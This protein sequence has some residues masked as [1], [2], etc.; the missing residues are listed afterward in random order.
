MTFPYGGYAGKGLYVDLSTG[1]IEP[2][3]V[4]AKTQMF[5]ERYMVD[6]LLQNS[7]G[8]SYHELFAERAASCPGFTRPSNFCPWSYSA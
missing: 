4:G 2:R 5:T 8:R 3:E 1:K 6:W 7:L